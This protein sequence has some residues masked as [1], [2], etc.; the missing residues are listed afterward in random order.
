MDLNLTASSEGRWR[1]RLV[2]ARNLETAGMVPFLA[3]F[4]LFLKLGRLGT[5]Q[6]QNLAGLAVFIVI[7]ANLLSYLVTVLHVGNWFNPARLESNYAPRGQELW[8]SAEI[9]FLATVLSILVVAAAVL[10][11]LLA[12][13]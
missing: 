5:N 1:R 11:L 3:L 9:P 8:A 2:W 6:E 7:T 12:G 10:L 4:F 13:R